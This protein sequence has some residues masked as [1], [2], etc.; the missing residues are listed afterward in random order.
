MPLGVVRTPARWGVFCPEGSFDYCAAL[1]NN[2]FIITWETNPASDTLAWVKV[3]PNPNGLV[4][5]I[6]SFPNGTFSKVGGGASDTMIYNAGA[7]YYEPS[8]EFLLDESFYQFSVSL[9]VNLNTGDACSGVGITANLQYI[10]VNEPPTASPTISGVRQVGELLTGADGYNDIDG[11]PQDT[12]K[13]LRRWYTYTDA[14]GTLGETLV[15]TSQTYSLNSG[16][17]GKYLRYKVT[18]AATSGVTP[19]AEASSAV[20]GPV[21]TDVAAFTYTTEKNGLHSLGFRSD[22][23]AEIAIDWGDGAGVQFL[24]ATGSTQTFSVTYPSAVSKTVNIYCDALTPERIDIESESVTG[25]IDVTGLLNCSEIVC[26]GNS[27][28]TG[29]T[30]ESGCNYFEIDFDNTGV[31][32]LALDNIVF[33]SNYIVRFRNCA[34]TTFSA[35]GTDGSAGGQFI[36]FRNIQVSGTLD[37]TWA[38]ARTGNGCQYQLAGANLTTNF[39]F[40]GAT[41][42]INFFSIGGSAQAGTLDLSGFDFRTQP[43]S[44]STITGATLAGLTALSLNPTGT[45]YL[46]NIAVNA[47]ALGATTFG[48]INV[49]VNCNYELQ[50]NGMTAAE[51][52]ETLVSIRDNAATS[53]ATGSISIGGTN[54]APDTTS[55]G[56]NGSQAVTDLVSYGYTVTT[57]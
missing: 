2:D 38:S 25:T 33:D 10:D 51:V 30:L 26:A 35:S 52:N 45:G 46:R 14:A 24:S 44:G 6:T 37:L 42:I 54:A 22:G 18:P 34:I 56:F 21:I 11:D 20:F 55:G 28:I 5:S 19:G 7:G 40:T 43:N 1:T 39:D 16:D 4:T 17:A 47:G 15:G 8:S 53:G 3:I 57:S 13:T 36:D 50:D 27:G 32:S 9:D 29:V 41:G 23:A 12:I 48:T 49:P 31:T